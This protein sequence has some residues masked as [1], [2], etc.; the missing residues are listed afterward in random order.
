MTGQGMLALAVVIAIGT[1]AA[2]IAWRPYVDCW[3]CHGQVKRRKNG[4]RAY[5]LC[6]WCKGKPQRLRAS[7]KA[8]NLVRRG[9]ARR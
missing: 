4:R 6:W 7:R 8:Y 2:D 3:A 5:G 1:W 9:T